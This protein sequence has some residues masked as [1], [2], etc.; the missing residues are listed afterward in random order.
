MGMYRIR[1]WS[2]DEKVADA[3][4][5][6][7]RYTYE[8]FDDGY[9][10]A[11]DFREFLAGVPYSEGEVVF[12]EYVENDGRKVAKRAKVAHVWFDRNRYGE[13]QELY[14]LQLETAKGVWAKVGTKA[15]AGQ[16]QR[17]YQLAG[18]APDCDEADRQAEETR[19]RLKAAARAE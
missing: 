14:R 9:R 18:L 12:V 16:V 4:V 7:H 5:A 6:P 17:G 8:G 10:D 3:Q 13:R 2:A 19:A 1:A 15:W 11:K